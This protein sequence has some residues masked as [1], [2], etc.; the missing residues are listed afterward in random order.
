MASKVTVSTETENDAKIHNKLRELEEAHRKNQTV[1]EVTDV[2]WDIRN[3]EWERERQAWI[4][5]ME[6]NSVWAMGSSPYAAQIQGK[7]RPETGQQLDITNEELTKEDLK[8]LVT[9]RNIFGLDPMLLRGTHSPHTTPMPK[10]SKTTT[11]T[12]QATTDT[13]KTSKTTGITL[14]TT[15][16]QHKAS[17]TSGVT[18]QTTSEQ[19]KSTKHGTVQKTVHPTTS[20]QATTVQSSAKT[21]RGVVVAKASSAIAPQKGRSHAKMKKLSRLELLKFFSEWDKASFGRRDMILIEFIKCYK[22]KDNVYCSDQLFHCGGSLIFGRFVV[23]M[24]MCFLK[25]RRVWHYFDAL[26]VF[27]KSLQGYGTVGWHYLF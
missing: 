23:S 10:S 16:T 6:E 15:L 8:Q 20:G 11:A 7:N 22:T 24:Q 17:K 25:H 5:Q 13:H 1:R 12:A 26:A 9:R 4:R 2:E 21:R 19:Y 18:L 14:Q 27:V 3:L